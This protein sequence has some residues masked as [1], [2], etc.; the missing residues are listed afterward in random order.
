MNADSRESLLP[1]QVYSRKVE[2]DFLKMERPTI[3]SPSRELSSGI[4]KHVVCSKRIPLYSNIYRTHPNIHQIRR[5]PTN[6]IN[7]R[8]KWT[9]VERDWDE[10]SFHWQHLP[11]GCNNCTTLGEL[12]LSF[13]CNATI[14]RLLPPIPLTGGLFHLCNI[15]RDETKRDGR[16]V[17]PPFE[18]ED[19][20][21]QRCAEVIKDAHHLFLIPASD[22]SATKWLT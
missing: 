12:F 11:I 13:S 6:K 5:H 20:S 3:I 7:L 1:R 19:W 2:T 9:Q 16:H 21:R 14:R 18:M 22:E 17:S 8:W 4:Y 10:T 15:N